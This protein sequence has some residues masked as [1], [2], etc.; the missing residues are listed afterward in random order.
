VVIIS[1]NSSNHIRIFASNTTS[2]AALQ[3]SNV[4]FIVVQNI[5]VGSILLSD[6]SNLLVGVGLTATIAAPYTFT[7]MAN[8]SLIVEPFSNLILDTGAFYG[9]IFG[10]GTI[11]CVNAVAYVP[12]SPPIYNAIFGSLHIPDNAYAT[13]GS[14]VVHFVTIGANST[15][16][17]NYFYGQATVT[18]TAT[19]RIFNSEARSMLVPYNSLPAVA[20]EGTVEIID[21][22][23]AIL[24][25][26][27]YT[28]NGT[29]SLGGTSVVDIHNLT[30]SLLNFVNGTNGAPSVTISGNGLTLAMDTEV[31]GNL[32]AIGSGIVL[33]EPV[34]V[35]GSITVTQSTL[36]IGKYLQLSPSSVLSLTLSQLILGG[37]LQTPVVIIPQLSTLL[38]SSSAGGVIGSLQNSGSVNVS[39][40]HVLQISGSYTQLQ[41][42]VLSVGISESSNVAPLVVNG[43]ISLAGTINY[44][45]A[46]VPTQSGKYL[47]ATG[48][49]ISGSFGTTATP[50]DTSAV[51]R[52][53]T[54]SYGKNSVYLAYDPVGQSKFP[55]WVWGIIVAVVLVVGIAVAVGVYR[56]RQKKLGY[57]PLDRGDGFDFSAD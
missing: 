29:L 50:L 33:T 34:R 56:Y 39:A 3:L 51:Q 7:L 23:L 46:T 1:T 45:I 10:H 22:Q 8:A 24:S 17:T 35:T 14:L 41:S 42:G 19:L 53:L 11:N 12:T 37:F 54:L 30:I 55:A 32:I 5:S 4:D 40:E 44:A 15:L 2:F 47:V 27:M 26:D 28:F 9:D 31:Q 52:S 49:T 6:E 43:S 16:E 20:G 21:S 13:F 57:T 25:P 36:A 48:Q 18:A 38:V